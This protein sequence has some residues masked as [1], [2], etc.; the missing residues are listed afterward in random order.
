MRKLALKQERFA[1]N[2][3]KG[4]GQRDAYIDAY[5]PTYAMTTV[6]AAAS[7]LAHNVRVV[8]YLEELSAESKG[9]TML[10]VDEKRE[11]YA[12]ITRSGEEETKDKLR[13]TD[14]DNKLA[15]HYEQ[16]PPFQ[17]NRQW[18]IVVANEAT[19]ESVE[20]LLRGDRR[21]LPEGE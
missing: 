18:T 1:N 13:A 19:K 3:F 5:H 6:D 20:S 8:A 2:L 4:M 9:K 12:N 11:F 16:P 17:D 21:E 10:E 15:R 14:L 7:R